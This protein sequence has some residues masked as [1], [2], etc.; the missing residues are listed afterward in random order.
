MNT[1]IKLV[2]LTLVG[3]SILG[4]PAQAQGGFLGQ[5]LDN[6]VKAVEKVM[7]D[8]GAAVQ[9]GVATSGIPGAPGVAPLIGGAATVVLAPTVAAQRTFG[10]GMQQLANGQVDVLALGTTYVQSHTYNDVIGLRRAGAIQSLQQC[11]AT[12]YASAEGAYGFALYKTGDPM[13][14]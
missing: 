2:A 13:L 4:A 10:T 14:A 1:K 3:L 5:V 9:M 12:V 8:P 11:Q 6:P 7:A